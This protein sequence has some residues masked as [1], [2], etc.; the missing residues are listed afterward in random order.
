MIKKNNKIV[1][2][3]DRVDL[4]ILKPHPASRSMPEWYRKMNGTTEGIMTVKKCVPF[5][6]SLALGYHIPLTAE[7]V[8]DGIS[9]N[10]NYNSPLEVVSR[11]HDTQ[12]EGVSLPPEFNKTPHKWINN[13]FVKT[14]RGYSTLFIHPLN[15]MDLPF[16]S[17][18]GVVDTDSH[19]MI[20]HFP[21]VLREDFSGSIPAG[22][23]IV[24]AI[25]FKRS[26]WD[27]E[28]IDELKSF[29]YEYTYKVMEP[30]FGWYKRNKWHRKLFR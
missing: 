29:Y 27:S 15:R 13:W 8:W 19:P 18:S 11:H 26:D 22:T 12:I 21:F 30:P 4:D 14:P 2:H 7:V 25:P 23:P 20:T 10:F 16:Y 6:D 5:L 1:F 28:T 17:F 9:Q 3:S 24:Q